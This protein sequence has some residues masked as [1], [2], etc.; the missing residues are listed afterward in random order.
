MAA[1]LKAQLQSLALSFDHVFYS[2]TFESLAERSDLT[3]EIKV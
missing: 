1:A 3:I 2:C